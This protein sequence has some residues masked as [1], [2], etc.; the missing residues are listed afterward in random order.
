MKKPVDKVNQNRA[1]EADDVLEAIH[2]IMH[3]VRSQQLRAPGVAELDLT[4]MESKVLGFF[5]RH[6][7]ATQSELALHSGRDKAQLTRLVR[8]LRDKG[9][10]AASADESDRRSTRL[11]LSA[12]GEALHARVA[13][14]RLRL[15]DLA[16][17]AL[18]P[19]EREQLRA[20]LERVQAS[21]SA[22]G[23]DA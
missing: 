22:A 8:G 13:E 23:R 6:P 2:S 14:Q 10:L 17:A 21:L 1:T 7:G 20:L 19:P 12:E 5:A 15:A 11:Q 4:H 18:A 3:M 9:L 16:L